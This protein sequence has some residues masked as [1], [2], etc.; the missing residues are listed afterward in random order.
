MFSFGHI[1]WLIISA[2]MITVILLLYNKYKPS[3]NKVLNCA[4]V[5]SLMSE[6]LKLFCCFQLV[7]SANG[8]LT[9]PYLPLNQLP[10]HLCSLQILF[11]IYARFTKQDKNRGYVLAFIYPTSVAGAASA[12]V[13]PSIF[14]TSISPDQAF[15]APVAYQFFIYH[16]MIFTL[17]VIIARSGEIKWSVTHFKATLII[18]LTATLLSFYLNSVFASPTYVDGKL[19]SV[20][21]STNFFYSYQ[22][23]LGIKF[24]AIWQWHIYVICMIALAV[25]IIFLLQYP[26]IFKKNKE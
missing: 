6:F 16:V 24:T 9:T 17:G 20:D 15:T 22:N 7:P 13:L 3:L 25:L 23:P 26:F 2:I 12:S 10:L 14:K 19:K 5:V 21:F 18:L 11:I 1:M 8:E 4:I